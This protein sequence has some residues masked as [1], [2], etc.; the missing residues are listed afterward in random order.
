LT[1]EARDAGA[2]AYDRAA[3]KFEHDTGTPYDFPEAARQHAAA[4]RA[5]AASDRARA[6]LDRD[7]AARDRKQAARD[8][9]QAKADLQAAQANSSP[10]NRAMD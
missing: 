2:L 5:E 6:A 3:A 1:A 10:P 8:R 4:A 9:A 7:Q